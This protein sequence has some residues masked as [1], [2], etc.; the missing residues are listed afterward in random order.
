[1][2]RLAVAAIVF[3]AGCDGPPPLSVDRSKL[4]EPPVGTD[5][6][7]DAIV[8]TFNPPAGKPMV[9]WYGGDA[10]D[11]WGGTGFTYDGTCNY[12]VTGSDGIILSDLGGQVP[13]HVTKIVHEMAHWTWFDPGHR[14]RHIWGEEYHDGEYAAGNAVGDENIALIAAGL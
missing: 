2:R 6:A 1:M 8:A 3:L 10:L 7:L 13:A 11:C 14:D 9:Y 12:G 5:A 4:V